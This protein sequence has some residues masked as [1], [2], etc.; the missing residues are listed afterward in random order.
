MRFLACVGKGFLKLSFLTLSLNPACLNT[1]VCLYPKEE[2]N[3]KSLSAP[4]VLN[5]PLPFK[6]LFY[7]LKPPLY[8]LKSLRTQKKAQR[9]F[10]PLRLKEPSH[11]KKKAQR[12]AADALAKRL[13]FRLR[14]PAAQRRRLRGAPGPRRRG[15]GPGGG[16]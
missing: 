7:S 6:L 3:P 9:S 14:G 8:A 12:P 16:L 1:L 11:P 4:Y 10:T 5:R 13:R 15:A 2:P